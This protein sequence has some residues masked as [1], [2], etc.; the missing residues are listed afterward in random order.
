[1]QTHEAQSAAERGA[2]GSWQVHRA[3]LH[4]GEEVAVKL[5]YPNL[6]KEMAS[7][8]AMFR[9]LGSQIKPGCARPG[10]RGKQG[11]WRG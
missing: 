8:F 3:T 11:G 2:R 7:D 4:S 9:R 10:C 6:R 1:M 5:L